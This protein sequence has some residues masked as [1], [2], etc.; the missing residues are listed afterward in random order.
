MRYL[1]TRLVLA[2][3]LL[4]LVLTAGAFST[5]SAARTGEYSVWEWWTN[6]AYTTDGLTQISPSWGNDY[7]ALTHDDLWDDYQILAQNQTW[8]VPD[9][10]PWSTV[11]THSVL[12]VEYAGWATNNVF[13][14]YN[15][16]LPDPITGGGV[17]F[18]GPTGGGATVD[19]DFTGYVGESIGFYLTANPQGSYTWYS[20]AD[21]NTTDNQTRHLRVFEHPDEA[22]AWVL[23]WE[24]K[25]MSSIGYNYDDA[26][27]KD[28]APLEWYAPTE[29]DYNDMILTFKWRIDG[30]LRTPEASTFL[31]LGLSLLAVPV[32]RRRRS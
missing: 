4:T 1:Q 5:A 20:E 3:I 30:K 16:V 17:I 7:A 14:W 10:S 25:P 27:D 11:D 15:P 21:R 32:L 9:P 2:T 23:A 18:S 31:L 8:V 13:G 29:P 26:W 12:E 22:G 19:I 28:Q 6:Q 24:D